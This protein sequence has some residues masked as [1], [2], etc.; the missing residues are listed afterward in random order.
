MDRVQVAINVN[1]S[2][3]CNEARCDY[4]INDYLIDL[5]EAAG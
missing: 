3:H 5:L 1:A 4:I 2:K